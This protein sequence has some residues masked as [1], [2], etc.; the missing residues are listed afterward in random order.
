MFGKGYFLRNCG[1]I[2]LSCGTRLHATLPRKPSS[3][4]ILSSLT[5]RKK[6]PCSCCTE[7]I[8][9]TSPG[10]KKG[11]ELKGELTVIFMVLG[12][13]VSVFLLDDGIFLV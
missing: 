11:N 7:L 6:R 9:R 12:G 5:E 3:V 8:F 1:S 13:C 10:Q 4:T 2:A